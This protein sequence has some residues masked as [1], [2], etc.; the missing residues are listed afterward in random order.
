M[1][2]STWKIK[3]LVSGLSQAILCYE[4]EGSVSYEWDG[5]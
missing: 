5:S 2:P 1:L 4:E 3:F